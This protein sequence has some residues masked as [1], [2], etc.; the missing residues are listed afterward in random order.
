MRN[1][2]SQSCYRPS[3]Y[4]MVFEASRFE[5]PQGL[6]IEQVVCRSTK[7]LDLPAFRQSW[8]AILNHHSAQRVGFMRDDQQ[9]PYQEIHPPLELPVFVEERWQ[10]ETSER[11]AFIEEWLEQDRQTNFS[12]SAP[13][14]MR[15]TIIRFAGD[16][17]T[18]VW[19]FHHILM[20]GHSLLLV[21]EDFFACYEAFCAGRTMVL[22]ERKPFAKFIAWH[23]S[24]MASRNRPS[25][26]PTA[27]LQMEDSTAREWRANWARTNLSMRS[28]PTAL[29]AEICLPPLKK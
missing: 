4:Q 9:E 18:W 11:E 3:P 1:P 5:E 23:Q 21:L 10:L 28:R 14:L 27:I 7:V 16:L 24:W 6:N 15:V 2:A 13:S 25:S 8:Q 26:S 19:T 17:I 29:S 22:P 12:L 20:D